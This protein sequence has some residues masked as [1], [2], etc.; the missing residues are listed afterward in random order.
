MNKNTWS[1]NVLEK[2]GEQNLSFVDKTE[3][4][5]NSET[6]ELFDIEMLPLLWSIWCSLF[7]FILTYILSADAG[8]ISS[9]PTL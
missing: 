9:M 3:V 7:Y 8:N 4:E 6:D 5:E 2:K 1:S